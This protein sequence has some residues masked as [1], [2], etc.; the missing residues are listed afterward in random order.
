MHQVLVPR[1]DD[2]VAVFLVVLVL[3]NH[4][5]VNFGFV[6]VVTHHLVLALHFGAVRADYLFFQEM[7]LELVQVPF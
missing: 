7:L 6:V 1:F 3:L 2:I 4:A 5:S